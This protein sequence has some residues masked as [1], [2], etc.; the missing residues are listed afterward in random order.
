MRKLDA[1]SRLPYTVLYFLPLFLIIPLMFHKRLK[2]TI[3]SASMIVFG[4]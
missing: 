2:N 3:F 1:P 4:V